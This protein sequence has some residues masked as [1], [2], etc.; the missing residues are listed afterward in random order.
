M[1]FFILYS[2]IRHLKFKQIVYQI[3]YRLKRP[4]YK[5]YELG[6]SKTAINNIC[7]FP[8]KYKSLCAEG[9]KFLNIQDCFT[10]WNDISHGPLWTYNLNYMDWI[11]QKDINFEEGAEWIDKFIS[12]LHKNKIGLDP[13]PIALRGIN[14]IKFIYLHKD[15]ISKERLKCWNDSLYSQYKLL[16][17]KLEYHLF[18]N[19]LLEDS[20]SLYIASIYFRDKK[21]YVKSAKLLVQQ[22][23]EQ[24]LP[25]GAH[26]EQSPMYHCILLDRLLDCYNISL[27]NNVFDNQRAMTEYLK[28]KALLMLGHLSSIVWTNG[29]IPLLND[30]AEKIAP[31]PQEILDYAASLSLEWQA[32]PLNDCGYRKLYAKDMEVIVDV[33]NI[34][35]TYQPG[36]THA[37]LFN[38]EIMIRNCRFIADTG[39]STYNKT[40]RRQYERSSRAHNTITVDNTDCYQVWGGFRVGKRA[41]ASIMKDEKNNVCA[42]YLLNGKQIKRSFHTDD[43]S[44][45]IIDEVSPATGQCE[46]Y[47]HLA[48]GVEI[49]RSDNKKIVTSEATIELSGVEAVRIE[50][51]YISTEYNVMKPSLCIVLT[52]IRSNNN[53]ISMS[54]IIKPDKN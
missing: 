53:T 30:S 6:H 16:E 1:N 46:S 35:A 43:S 21:M 8:F 12:D 14:W 48:D 5:K 45:R 20:Y 37:D 15:D 31:S 38:Y 51:N 54:Y 24:I 50:K 49:K 39:I 13:Y 11:L 28:Q 17:R 36:H 2:T 32:I 41:H 42:Q 9:F 29:E 27:N 18:G 40:E 3:L 44:L 25:D 52:P 26:Y 10:D 22:L 33:G 19:H 4:Q 47:I 7:L 34:M 23:K